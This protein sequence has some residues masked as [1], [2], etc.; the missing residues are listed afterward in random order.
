MCNKTSLSNREFFVLNLVQ[1]YAI[2]SC[3]K[4]NTGLPLYNSPHYNTDFNITQSCLGSQ[5][6]IFLLF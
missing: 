3:L 1:M 5:M 2:N 4:T 6:V